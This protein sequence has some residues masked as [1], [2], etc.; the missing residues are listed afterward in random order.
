MYHLPQ[1]ILL[2]SNRYFFSCC[3]YDFCICHENTSDDSCI[4]GVCPAEIDK[5]KG[6]VL[7]VDCELRQH[8]PKPAQTQ[9]TVV[10]GIFMTDANSWTSRKFLDPRRCVS[11]SSSDIARIESVLFQ[12]LPF[13]RSTVSSDSINQSRLRRRI[14]SS[15]VFS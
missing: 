2:G 14:R 3:P 4:A 11:S 7:Q 5:P 1:A 10:R 15:E 12:L 9:N 13:S 8:K 6:C